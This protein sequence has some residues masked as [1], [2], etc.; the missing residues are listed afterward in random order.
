MEGS[1]GGSFLRQDYF[2]LLYGGSFFSDVDDATTLFG[3]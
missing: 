2:Y 1:S 3:K